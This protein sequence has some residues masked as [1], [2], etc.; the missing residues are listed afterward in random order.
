VGG[1]HSLSERNVERV[2]NAEDHAELEIRA[3]RP[4]VKRHRGV[5]DRIPEEAGLNQVSFGHPEVG[6]DGLKVSITQQR[7]LDRVIGRQLPLQQRPQLL[8]S[9]LVQ[10][11]ASVP[12]D[13]RSVAF[14]DRSADFGKSCADIDRRTAAENEES[15]KRQPSLS[16][17]PPPVAPFHYFTFSMAVIVLL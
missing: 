10:F 13:L 17:H 1:R 4:K 6:V 2:Q 11:G 16:S 12:R 5:E 15:K 14:F 7:D 3:H 8:G 9:L